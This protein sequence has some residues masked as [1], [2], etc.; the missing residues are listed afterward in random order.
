MRWFHTALLIAFISAAASAATWP[1]AGRVLD[2]QGAPIAGAEVTAYFQKYDSAGEH[3]ERA[4]QTVGDADGRFAIGVEVPWPHYS[5]TLIVVARKGE[6]AFSWASYSFFGQAYKP[7]DITLE[8]SA[9]IAGTVSDEAGNPISGA[10]VT[11][12]VY[13]QPAKGKGQRKIP[14]G[15]PLDWLRTKTD[16]DGHFTITNLPKTSS[17][18]LHVTLLGKGGLWFEKRGKPVGA[19]DAGDTNIRATLQPEARIQGTVVDEDSRKPV[20]G[21][22][23]Q[24]V[25][26]SEA[27][28]TDRQV[29][30]TG[31]DGAFEASGLPPADYTISLPAYP[32]APAALAEPVAVKGLQAGETRKGVVLP[33]S[34]GGLLQVFVTN[35][36]KEPVSGAGVMLEKHGRTDLEPVDI[37]DSD[38]DGMAVFRLRPGAYHLMQVHSELYY[39][40]LHQ[41]RDEVVI[42]KGKTLRQDVTVAEKPR[43][44]GVVLDLQGK[45]VAGAPVLFVPLDQVPQAFTGA[46]GKFLVHCMGSTA[47]MIGQCVMVRIPEADL[48]G[49]LELQPQEPLDDLKLIVAPGITITGTVVDAENRPISGAQVRPQL[50]RHDG[51][52]TGLMDANAATDADGKYVIRNLPAGEDYRVVAQAD[53]FTQKNSPADLSTAKDRTVEMAPFALQPATL[54]VSGVV[55]DADGKPVD[56]VWVSASGADQNV[57]PA[58]SD[59]DGKFTLKN[60][61]D[62]PLFIQAFKRVTGQQSMGSINYSPD[63]KEVR[64]VMGQTAQMRPPEPLKPKSLAGKPLPD[65]KPFGLDAPKDGKPI[66][67]CFWSQEQRPS[68]QCMSELLA[69]SQSPEGRQLTILTIQAEPIERE[70]LSQWAEKLPV[71]MIEKDAENV[72]ARWGVRSLPW[73]LLV[74]PDGA[75]LA[76]GFQLAEWQDIW[77]AKSGR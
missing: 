37:A 76:E 43:I 75:V 39:Q 53:G 60:I 47:T 54:T 59:K 1:L 6:L 45:P 46:D 49:C 7:K 68:R 71:G 62:G 72:R 4:A 2:T 52:G 30:V 58:T 56:S 13:L 3:L 51:G 27:V 73:L 24:I 50:R 26:K 28:E 22:R 41:Q 14:G 48:A 65:L 9:S 19:F 35:E 36:K 33:T 12:D 25:A 66:L 34:P 77:K 63:M 44:S 57:Q 74:A 67:L 11:A 42:E 18:D 70:A 16:A 69:L 21:A 8:S 31:P 32:Q 5:T 10:Q 23:I 17:A 20:A 38:K 15:P 64:I 29:L 61:C 55:V 40:D